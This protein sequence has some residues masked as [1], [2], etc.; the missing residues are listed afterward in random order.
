[1]AAAFA[2]DGGTLSYG[3]N[4]ASTFE[5]CAIL[6]AKI[7][8]GAKAADLPIERPTK[9][10]FIVNLKAAKAMGLTVPDFVLV[11]ADKVIR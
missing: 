2:E 11:R 4:A 10:D 6:V 7:L 1:M 9:F 8:A 3:P 5:Q